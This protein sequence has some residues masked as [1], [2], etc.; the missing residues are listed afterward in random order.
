MLITGDLIMKKRNPY[1]AIQAIIM[2]DM[3][4]VVITADLFPRFMV[5]P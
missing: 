5:T 1:P 4:M 2:R 3:K